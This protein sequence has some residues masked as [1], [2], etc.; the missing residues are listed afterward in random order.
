[1]TGSQSIS[2][3]TPRTSGTSGGHLR[4]HRRAAR[5]IRGATLLRVSALL[6]IVALVLAGCGERG[7]VGIFASIEREEKI[8]KSNLPENATAGSMVYDSSSDKYYV[9]M[10]RLFSRG[11]SESDWDEVDHP[12][13]YDEG[14]TLDIVNVDGTIYAA[15]FKTDSTK[16]E[17]FELNTG[18]DKWDKVWDPGKEISKLIVVNNGTDDELFAVTVDSNND[19][20]NLVHDPAGAP[21]R[22]LSDVSKI[23]D[24][25]Y[26]G[27]Y[28]FVSASE[29]WQND[30]LATTPW[31]QSNAP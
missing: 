11:E 5:G 27:N 17:L 14:H 1:M 20:Y 22:V 19:D 26:D 8:E 24:G 12:S 3:S 29:F 13:G 15:F 21:D 2:L 4:R 16:S 31:D 30:D 25:A 6:G 9:A 23:F 18:N 28:F 7:N 10:G